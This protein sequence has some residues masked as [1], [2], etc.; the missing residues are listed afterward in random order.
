MRRGS[1]TGIPAP[2]ATIT[3]QQ[4]AMNRGVSQQ[5]RA[6]YAARHPIHAGVPTANIKRPGEVINPVDPGGIQPPN[7]TINPVDQGGIQP[8]GALSPQQMWESQPQN[9]QRLQKAKENMYGDYRNSATPQQA[10]SDRMPEGMQ[11]QP[12][13]GGSNQGFGQQFDPNVF[14]RAPMNG[15]GQ[16]GQQPIAPW[17]NPKFAGPGS[18][19]MQQMGGM[20]GG[21]PYPMQGMPTRNTGP[22]PMQPTGRGLMNAP[23]GRLQR[24][25]PG[26]YR[27]ANGQ[28]VR[29]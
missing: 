8:P 9:Q 4:N 26:I 10:W 2:M 29:R 16:Q 28:T 17:Q 24:L 1:K 18:S 14:G 6:D 13:P 11:M 25:S 21:V 20:F 5:H 7:Q 27:D 12:Y 3:P 19:A 23:N 15:L 22:A